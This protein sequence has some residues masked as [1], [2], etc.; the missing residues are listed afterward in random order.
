MKRGTKWLLAVLLPLLLCGVG[1]GGWNDGLGTDANCVALWKFE[2][3]ALTA[4]SGSLGTNTLTAVNTPVADAVNFKQGAAS[5]DFESGDKDY[6]KIT[7]AALSAGFPGKSGGHAEDFSITF[8]LKW[9]SLPGAGSTKYVISK[10]QGGGSFTVFMTNTGGGSPQTR[11]ALNTNVGANYYTLTHTLDMATGKWYH[12]GAI[13]DHGVANG[14]FIRV[15]DADT[16]TATT[17]TGTMSMSVGTNLLTIGTR[18]DPLES[19]DFMFDGLIDEMAV[20]NRALTAD[21]V[22]QIRSGTY[23]TLGVGSLRRDW[24]LRRRNG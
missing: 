9:E 6:F 19:S 14:S 3:G 21:E 10:Y 8:W 12:V 18:S 1:W 24:W 2:S 23:G 5:C 15:Y 16:D 17:K 20:L 11:I 7:D 22:D 4:D 13:C